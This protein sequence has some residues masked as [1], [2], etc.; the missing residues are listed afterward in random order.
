MFKRKISRK[1]RS[2]LF[3]SVTVFLLIYCATRVDIVKNKILHSNCYGSVTWTVIK[4]L[5]KSLF[6]YYLAIG[7]LIHMNQEFKRDLLHCILLQNCQNTQ[8]LGLDFIIESVMNKDWLKEFKFH[9]VLS[10]YFEPNKLELF[11]GVS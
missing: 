9:T 10:Q 6:K 7:I 1:S 4:N 2:Y 11:S 5:E 8:P 3:P